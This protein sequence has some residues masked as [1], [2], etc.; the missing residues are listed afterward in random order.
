MFVKI[1]DCCII[2]TDHVVWV[3]VAED[4]KMTVKL[5]DG[6]EHVVQEDKFSTAMSIINR[7]AEN[8]TY[9]K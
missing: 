2:N 1:H 8:A 5:T 4:N 3:D 6:S 9:I 7:G